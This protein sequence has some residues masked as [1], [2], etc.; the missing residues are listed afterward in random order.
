[1]SITGLSLWLVPQGHAVSSLIELSKLG[2]HVAQ[3]SWPAALHAEALVF[4][5]ENLLGAR[6]ASER[7]LEKLIQ[8]GWRGLQ[9]PA[10]GLLV[11]IAPNERAA[12][13]SDRPFFPPSPPEALAVAV[14]L[15]DLVADFGVGLQR[16]READDDLELVLVTTEAPGDPQRPASGGFG[17]G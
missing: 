14:D 10:G 3:V 6:V 17:R 11:G 4:V 8:R 7:V 2:E 5:R 12:F 9:V 15:E 1:M 16:L 13:L